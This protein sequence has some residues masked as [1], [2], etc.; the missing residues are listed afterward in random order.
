MTAVP[1]NFR[2][3]G[4]KDFPYFRRVWN[5]VVV[6]LMAASFIPLVLIGG[7][8]YYYAAS[9]LKEKTLEALRMEVVN[10]K[11]AI[12]Q[13]L[14]KRIMVLKLLSDNLALSSLTRPGALENVFKSLQSAPGTSYFVDLGIIDDRGRHLAY[15][16]PYN[17]ISRNYKDAAWFKAVMERGTYI[18]DV[19]PGFR[20]VPHFVVAVKHMDKHRAWIIRATVNS[21]NFDAT[22]SGVAEERGG[23]AYLI[24][25]NGVFQT[26]PRLAGQLMGP[27]ECEDPEP[28]KGVRL[29]EGGGRLRAMVWLEKVPWLCVV[30]VDQ[31]QVFETLGRVRKLGIF[32]FIMGGIL[33]VMAVL[34]TTNHLV[35]R[36][37]SKRRSIRVLDQQ[38]RRTSYLASS[39]EMSYGFFREIKDTLANMDVA[40]AWVQDVGRKR[41]LDGIDESVDQIKSEVSR[42]RKSIDKFLRFIR[43]GEPIITEIGINKTL[44]DLLGFLSSEL[45]FKGIQVKLDY[46]DDLPP[47]RSDRSK[48][49]QVFQN[50]VLNAISAIEKDGEITISTR[51][52]DKTVIVTVTDN[53]PGISRENMEK[54]FDPLFTT[55]KDG[56]GLGLS[57]CS[58]ILGKLGGNIS[59]RSEPGRGASFVIEIPFQF[60]PPEQ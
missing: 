22:V 57:I 42:C 35:Q 31:T 60:L 6:A 59:A 39:M 21:I 30:Q 56:T 27:S 4:V 25:R 49:R 34:L 36:L 12:D 40:A 55:K 26:R 15:V 28:F 10:H 58:E 37:E 16:G 46:Q 8:M 32:V 7:G 2:Q 5:N 20:K 17:L 33:I 47:I 24:N 48:L 1:N 29:K 53:G 9:I 19:F 13:F 18:S 54:I 41:D 23:D 51:A 3:S 52:G 45:H 14:E 11:K 44:D 43:P 38:L 50:V